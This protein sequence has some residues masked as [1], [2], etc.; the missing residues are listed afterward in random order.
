MRTDV[1]TILPL[2][3]PSASP[4]NPGGHS[5]Q[6]IMIPVSPEIEKFFQIIAKWNLLFSHDDLKSV[7]LKIS[8]NFMEI[9]SKSFSKLFMVHM[10]YMS[11]FYWIDIQVIDKKTGV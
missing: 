2:P 1:E 11:T 10:A 3:I 9:T 8:G 6:G 5:C 7:F 4:G